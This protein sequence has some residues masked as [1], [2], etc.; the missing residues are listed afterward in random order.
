MKYLELP[1]IASGGS[2]AAIR[3]IHR[4]RR[5]LIERPA[6][7]FSGCDGVLLRGRHMA[8]EIYPESADD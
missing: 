8:F 6:A 7:G 1:H 3:P 2:E 4:V 5:R